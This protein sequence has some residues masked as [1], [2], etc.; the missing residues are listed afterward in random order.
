[1]VASEIQCE[2]DS[3][4]T[5]ESSQS[6][7]GSKTGESPTIIIASRPHSSTD[8]SNYSENHIET[9][10]QIAENNNN[11]LRVNNYK[12]NQSF[13][14]SSYIVSSIEMF[15]FSLLMNLMKIII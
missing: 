15:Y 8:V 10:V 4:Q 3:F 13:L 6:R 5:I 12:M 14:Y 1:M 11:P 9:A 7:R 2:K